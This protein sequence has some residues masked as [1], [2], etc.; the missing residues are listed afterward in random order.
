LLD[1]VAADRCHDAKLRE[2]SPDGIDHRRL[3]PDQQM[4][5]ANNFAAPVS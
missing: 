3:L 4:A 2:V 1:T 5:G